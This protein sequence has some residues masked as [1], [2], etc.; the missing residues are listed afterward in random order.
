MVADR[1]SGVMKDLGNCVERAKKA[2]A[3]GEK[4]G[5]HRLAY[6]HACVEGGLEEGYSMALT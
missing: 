6:G 3:G 2:A 4:Q 1:Y 5:K